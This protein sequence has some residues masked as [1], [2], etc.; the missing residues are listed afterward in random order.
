MPDT[1]WQWLPANLEQRIINLVDKEG[2]HLEQLYLLRLDPK[3]FKF[4]VAY[5]ATP[6]SLADWQAETGAL[7]L[8]NGGYYRRE[9]E[10][11]IPTGL[12]VID[13]K[14]MGQS[15]GAFAGMLAVT[16]QGPE[17]RWLAQQPYDP[18]EPLRAALQS[19]PLLVK[20]GGE[21]GF[22]A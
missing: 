4:G 12:T 16:D 13:G 18:G 19:F 8:I 7:V 3:L 10:I 11:A 15:Y 5:H 20:P 2:A 6:Q 14:A 22:L 21:I 1:G 17:L 9:G